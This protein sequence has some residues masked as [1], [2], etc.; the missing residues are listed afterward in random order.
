MTFYWTTL[1]LHVTL[2]SCIVHTEPTT[3]TT[4]TTATVLRP[5][6]DFIRDY[7]GAPVP[8]R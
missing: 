2:L 4:T 7:P 3:T 1:Y 5:P 6:L 8:E